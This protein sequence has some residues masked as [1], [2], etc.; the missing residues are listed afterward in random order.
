MQRNE[1]LVLVSDLERAL[2]FTV[3]GRQVRERTFVFRLKCF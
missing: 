1:Q 3:I 2:G